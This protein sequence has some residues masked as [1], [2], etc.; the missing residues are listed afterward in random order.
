M[1]P[2]EAIDKIKNGEYSLHMDYDNVPL[3]NKILS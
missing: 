3:L 2:Q 1:T